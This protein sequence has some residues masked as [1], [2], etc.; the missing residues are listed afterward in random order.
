[1]LDIFKYNYNVFGATALNKSIGAK[2]AQ[3]ITTTPGGEA[4]LV[5]FLKDAREGQ[6]NGIYFQQV[7]AVKCLALVKNKL[8]VRVLCGALADSEIGGRAADALATMNLPDAPYA[9]KTKPAPKGAEDQMES[10]V[11][12]EQGQLRRLGRF[13]RRLR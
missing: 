11:G 1:M 5:K 4:Y 13:S 12:R 7:S 2:T 3:L 8:A 9:A 10:L 6:P